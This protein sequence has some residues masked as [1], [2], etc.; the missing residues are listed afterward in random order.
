MDSLW[1]GTQEN[2][3]QEILGAE[4]DAWFILRVVVTGKGTSC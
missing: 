2:S 4:S 1:D 3:S